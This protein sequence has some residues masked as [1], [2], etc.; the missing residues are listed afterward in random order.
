MGEVSSQCV[1]LASQPFIMHLLP[2]KLS[3]WCFSEKHC[4]IALVPHDDP[5]ESSCTD[6]RLKALK[7]LPCICYPQ[8]RGEGHCLPT[9]FKTI[10][11]LLHLSPPPVPLFL[12]LLNSYHSFKGEVSRLPT[13]PSLPYITSL[14][15]GL[16][17]MLSS[18]SSSPNRPFQHKES[19]HSMAPLEPQG[20]SMQDLL[21]V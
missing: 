14:S 6:P 10:A 1:L 11:S 8:A 21:S 7:H 15:S 20:S 18:T 5:I 3:S 19:P 4:Q 13:L 16:H 17:S 12:Y 9:S 2:H